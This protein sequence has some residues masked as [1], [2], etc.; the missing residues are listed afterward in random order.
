MKRIFRGLCI[1]AVGLFM[2]VVEV[3][4]SPL[5]NIV[6]VKGVVQVK[7]DSDGKISAITI[8]T[9]SG[10]SVHVVLNKTGNEV[11]RIDGYGIF[12]AG[13]YDSHGDLMITTWF[14]NRE[15]EKKQDGSSL[16]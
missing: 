1:V 11:V 2:G 14:L 13:S 15:Y 9:I 7:K 12:A 5:D 3:Q 6:I 16:N 10:S 8:K 4:A